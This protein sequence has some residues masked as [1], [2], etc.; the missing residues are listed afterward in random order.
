MLFYFIFDLFRGQFIINIFQ[1]PER[2]LTAAAD[3]MNS[4]RCHLRKKDLVQTPN[5]ER[6]IPFRIKLRNLN[7]NI[8]HQIQFHVHL[9]IQLTPL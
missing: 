8:S 7:P 3:R 9:I 1:K 2:A 4:R 6:G 5:P